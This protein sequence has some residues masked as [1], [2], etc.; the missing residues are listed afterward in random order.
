MSRMLAEIE[1]IPRVVE[2]LLADG[3]GEADA[4]ARAISGARPAWA[5][6]VARGT[7]DHAATYA[8]YLFEIE[9]GLPTGLAAPSVTTLYGADLRWRGGLVVAISQSGQSPDVVG[10]VE[11]ARA[12]GALTVALTNETRSPLAAAAEHVIDCRAGTE[13]AVAATKTYVA[14]LA[15]IAML[16][17]RLAPRTLDPGALATLPQAL[18][19]SLAEAARQVADSGLVETMAGSDRALVASRG[20]NLATALEIALKLKETAGIFADGYS[21]ADL[22]HGPVA[23]AEPGL[24]VLV[25]RPEGAVGQAIDHALER[26]LAAG[27]RPWIIS[28]RSR[29]AG[30]PL[31]VRGPAASRLDERQVLLRFDLPEALSPLAFILPGQLLA[32]AATRRRG[33]DPDRLPSLTK[34]TRTF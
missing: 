18:G 9:L 26:L 12:G 32:E 14:E 6:I 19:D 15:V 34:V 33:R 8:R 20:Y 22:E 31:S 17:A 28:G 11:E 4:A 3:R 30:G 7:S 2:R 10:V 13:E 27:V 21:T 5:S 16:V 29:S 23:L 25:I 24:P 1:E